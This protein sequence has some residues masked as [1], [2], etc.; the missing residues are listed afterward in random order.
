MAGHIKQN[1][2]IILVFTLNNL[3][4]QL[5]H[6]LKHIVGAVK[7]TSVCLLIPIVKIDYQAILREPFYEGLHYFYIQGLIKTQEY[8]KAI[9]YYDEI[10]EAFYALSILKK[11]L[12]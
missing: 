11:G 10:N 6:V 7:S 3:G 5:I 9:Q 1:E 4:S 12:F 8:H 2:I